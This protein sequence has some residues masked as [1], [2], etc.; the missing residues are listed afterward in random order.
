MKV[1]PGSGDNK[2]TTLPKRIYQTILKDDGYFSTIDPLLQID[3]SLDVRG[4]GEYLLSLQAKGKF[5]I[6][7]Q[8]PDIP[9]AYFAP[10]HQREQDIGQPYYEIL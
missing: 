2:F 10:C 1:P 3:I 6:K 5:D 4:M 9:M 8:P 7:L